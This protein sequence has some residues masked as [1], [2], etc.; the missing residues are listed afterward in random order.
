VRSRATVEARPTPS[1][2][3]RHARSPDRLPVNFSI[4]IELT[5]IELTWPAMAQ[6]G[7]V[8][9][10]RVFVQTN[11]AGCHAVGQTGMSPLAAAPPLRE[12]HKRYP[13]ENLAEAFAEGIVTGHPSMPEF[14]LDTAQI[15]DLLAYLKSLEP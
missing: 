12:L 10:G 2:K 1:G 4:L 7:R 3:P 9:R 8:Q 13:V 15:D 5:L 14:R 6:D 11:C